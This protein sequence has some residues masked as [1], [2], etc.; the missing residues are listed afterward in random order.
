MLPS[1]TWIVASYLLSELLSSGDSKSGGDLN[2][3][4]PVDGM[5]SKR[6]RVVAVSK[7]IGE[8]VSVRIGRVEVE[9]ETLVFGNG[10]VSVRLEC[11]GLV[12]CAFHGAGHLDEQVEWYR[13]VSV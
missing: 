5:I 10:Q 2:A 7:R 3:S 8:G 11:G 13:S 4:N 12:G 9:H 6:W 1:E